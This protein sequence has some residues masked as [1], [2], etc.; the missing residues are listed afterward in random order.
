MDQLPKAILL[1]GFS[2]DEIKELLNCYRKNKK[3]PETIF[4]SVTKTALN[5]KVKDWL[6]E[7]Q[8][9]HEEFKKINKKK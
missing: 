2:N 9:E 3:L 7:L 4:A 8:A 6:K 1:S 5:W